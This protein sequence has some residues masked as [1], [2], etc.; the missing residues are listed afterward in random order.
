MNRP[1]CPGVLAHIFLGFLA[2][3]LSVH[4]PTTFAASDEDIAEAGDIVQ[5]L[6]PISGYVGAW[7][8]GDKE[9]AFQLTKALG[10]A[11]ITA[12]TIKFTGARLR[13]DG[14]DKNSFPS[15]HTTAAYSGAEFI[16]IRYGNGWGVPAHIAAAF[17]AYSRVR[18]NK[19]FLDDVLAGASNGMMWNWYFTSPY[20]EV[21]DL[22][23]MVLEDGYAVEFAYN[24]DG[25]VR[26]DAD[27]SDQPRFRYNFEFGPVTQ[28]KNLFT[29]PSASGTELDLATAEDEFDITSQVT[30]QY[31]S[32]PRHEWEAYLAPLELVEFDPA[33]LIPGPVDF[34]GTTF[35]PTPGSTFRSRYNFNEIRL[36]YR[37][38]LIDSEKWALKLGGG[39]QYADTYLGIRQFL[40]DSASEN[41]IAEAEAESIAY[42]PILTGRLSY[43]FNYKWRLEYELDG[44]AGG[45]K[46]INTALILNYRAAPGWDLG[47][48]ARYSNWEIDNATVK[49]EL[50]YGDVVFR[51]AHMF[52]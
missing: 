45:E 35:V 4:A 10:A 15:G 11:G 22:Q 41:I 16:R 28:D 33:K 18:A 29:S 36:V 20:S 12:Q 24:F 43:N 19:H 40:G 9:G 51:V 37:Y 17:V 8:A 21:L 5:I 26:T 49:N 7:I 46:Y 6:L 32:S 52:F 25:K 50:E 39:L 14:T 27:Y 47:V 31:F 30:F 2:V 44:V 3:A 1:A 48:G 34:A 23:P 38:A 13:P 42:N